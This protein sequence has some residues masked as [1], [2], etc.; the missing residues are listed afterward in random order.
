MGT[1]SLDNVSF[2]YEDLVG[3]G[4]VQKDREWALENVSLQIP[5]GQFLCLIGHSGS[6]K[7]T[8]LRLLLGLSKP[9]SGSIFIDGSPVD[10]PGLDRSFV[11]QNY[12]L[13]PWMKVRDN[14]EF[15]IEQAN[16]ALH[17]GLSKKDIAD[18]ASLYLSRVSM[19]E[20]ADMYPYQ[21][22]G[23]MKQRVA[24]ARALAMDTEILLFDEPFGALDVKT[25]CSL[26]K[27]IDSLWRDGKRR[28][29]VVFVTHD[30][31]EAILLADRVVFMRKGAIHA[32]RLIEL[33][34]P[35]SSKLLSE[36][37]DGRELAAFLTDCFYE[38]A[39][40]EDTFPSAT[41]EPQIGGLP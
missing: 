27:L 9:T 15:G 3:S 31:S 28:K 24:I 5:D 8:L 17:R 32:D 4:T 37:E 10:G 11:L 30:I 19:L 12:S 6:G 33:P 7:S 13:F 20:A 38:D 16:K 18:T 23:G 26:Q 41:T 39:L 21:L 22:S 29:T 2:A 1:I 34:R 14:V 40:A 25:R 36:S 35:R